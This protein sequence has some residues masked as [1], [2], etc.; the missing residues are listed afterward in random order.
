M[1]AKRDD[2]DQSAAADRHTCSEAMRLGS[3]GRNPCLNFSAGMVQAV[4]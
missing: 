4:L 3:A 1:E 2:L